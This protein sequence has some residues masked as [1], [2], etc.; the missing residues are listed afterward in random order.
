MLSQ[1][2]NCPIDFPSL[3]GKKDR[4]FIVQTKH[5]YP[6]GRNQFKETVTI[7]GATALLLHFD[8]QS[9]TASS[10]SDVLQL[11][12]ANPDQP[13]P[14]EGSSDPI[15]FSGTNFPRHSVTVEGDTVTFI[16]NSGSRPDSHN[17]NSP[18]RWGFRCIVTE[19]TS[20]TS[21]QPAMDHWSLDL[22]CNL[23]VLCG[24]CSC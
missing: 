15:Y 11:F 18:S 13:V 24:K 12:Y 14:R 3:R 1:S 20:S 22:E 16:F 6:Y 9:R 4:K 21:F 19:L 7:P 2:R 10:S 23:G 5:P 17:K 8:P